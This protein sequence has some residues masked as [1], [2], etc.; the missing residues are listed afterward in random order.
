MA[1]LYGTTMSI[2]MATKQDN[3][4]SWS[5]VQQQVKY[6]YYNYRWKMIIIITVI[7]AVGLQC[8]RKLYLQRKIVYIQ[9]KPMN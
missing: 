9:D 4:L 1:P 5:L 6:Y 3:I 2:C 8:Q 7:I